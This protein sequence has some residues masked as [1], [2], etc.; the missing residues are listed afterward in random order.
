MSHDGQS[1]MQKLMTKVLDQP[2][3]ILITWHPQN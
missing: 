1:G 2:G 3:V